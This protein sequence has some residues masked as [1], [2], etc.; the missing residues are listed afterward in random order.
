MRKS[1]PDE[2]AELLR[3]DLLARRVHR[4][5]VGR[6]RGAVQVVGAHVE[7]VPPELSAEPHPRSRLELVDELSLVEPDGRD[8]PAIVRDPRLDDREPGPWSPNRGADDLS[9][10]RDFLLPGEQV[11][12]PHLVGG[13]LVA[14]WTMREQITDRAQ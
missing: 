5:K 8:L 12:D 13:G 7:L 2:L 3:R 10:D 14:V 9:R 1:L 11:G 6:R 4:R